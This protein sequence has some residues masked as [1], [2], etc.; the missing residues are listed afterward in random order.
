MTIDISQYLKPLQK[1]TIEEKLF[2]TVRKSDTQTHITVESNICQEKC[3]PKYCTNACPAI[4][5][6]V[7][8]S[9]EVTK[10]SFENCVEC[11]TCLVSCPYDAINWVYPRG[12]FGVQYKYG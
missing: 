2:T 3:A 12:G 7:E 9:T 8:K 10:A 5:Y 1:T 6:S 4:V 11:G